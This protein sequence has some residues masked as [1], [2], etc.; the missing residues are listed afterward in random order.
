MC[1]GAAIFWKSK[2]QKKVALASGEAEFR[3][4]SYALKEISFCIYLL[5]ELGFNCRY[6]PVFSD[7]SVSIAQ[8]KRD[9]LSWVEG[10]KQ[11]EIELSA[12]FQMCHEGMIMP[13]KIATNENPADLLTKSDPG[14]PEVRAKHIARIS[15]TSSES[16]QSWITRQLANFNGSTVSRHG[17]VS[18]SDF[19]MMCGLKSK[20]LLL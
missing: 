11:Y 20:K 12:A 7:A 5:T 6:V 4:L 3:A 15:G 8:A 1:Q 19:E 9:G 16:F 17:Y 18:K 10:T 2:L 14:G 13:L